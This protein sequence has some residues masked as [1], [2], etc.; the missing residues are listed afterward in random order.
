MTLD[1]QETIEKLSRRFPMLDGPDIDWV[2]AEKIHVMYKAL[3]TNGQSLEKI[4]KRGGFGWR[5][6]SYMTKM[7]DKK[8]RR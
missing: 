7:T 8:K 3:Y 1:Q 2:T 5:E 4:A 6:V